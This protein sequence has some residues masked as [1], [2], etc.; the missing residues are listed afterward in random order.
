M[1]ENL[2]FENIYCVG[3]NFPE[4]AKELGNKVP[5]S[6]LIFQKSN[7]TVNTGDTIK[8]PKNKTIEHE[9]EIVLMIGREGVPKS[10]EQARAFI[11]GFSTGLDL[12]DRNLQAQLKKEGLPWFTSKSFKGSAVIDRNFRHECPS[13]FYLTVN[14]KIRQEGSLKDMIFSFEDII[15]HISKIV[16]FKKGDIIF[17]GTPEGV[18][19]LES[20]D[21]V[22]IGFKNHSPKKLFVI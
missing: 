20:G 22:E 2:K 1:I 15:L 6:P 9:L 19:P 14:Q 17:T 8:I 7:S 13:E 18:G 16:D 5:T 21:Q 11:S 3:R 12:T 10:H 4:H